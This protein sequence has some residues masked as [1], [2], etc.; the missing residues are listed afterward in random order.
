MKDHTG[1]VVYMLALT[2][3][4]A[5]VSCGG[6]KVARMWRGGACE[7]VLEGA[8]GSVIVVKILAD[9]SVVTGAWDGV[10]RIWN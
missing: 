5:L 3:D 6:D 1:H 2:S 8:H 10:V 4:G 9:N 7:G